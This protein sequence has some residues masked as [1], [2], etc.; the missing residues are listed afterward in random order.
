MLDHVILAVSDVDRSVDLYTATL[1]PLGITTRVDY[2]GKD[3][4]LVVVKGPID[5]AAARA[6][7][8]DVRRP[9]RPRL[10]A[11]DSRV[12]PYGWCLREIQNP[13]VDPA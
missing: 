11:E 13:R 1:A 5:R 6:G 2:D 9:E 12:R 3:G 10:A 7:I 8:C 4:V